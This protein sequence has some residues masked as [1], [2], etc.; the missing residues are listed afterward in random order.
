MTSDTDL[1][2]EP[3][4]DLP[5]PPMEG[6]GL[7]GDPAP[8]AT[9]PAPA[10]APPPVVAE[11]APAEPSQPYRVLARKYRPLDFND[12]IGQEALVR[13]LRNAFAQN[14]VAHAFMLTGVR[15]VGKTTTARIIARALN[16]IGP[17]GNGG[18]TADPCGVCPECRAI[19]A[20]RHPD[21]VEMDAASNNSVDNVREIREAVRFRPSQGRFKVYILDEVHMLSGAAFNALLKTLEEPPPAVKFL[22]ATTEIRKVPA[23]ILSR[24][25]RFDLKRVPQETLRAHFARIVEKEGATIEPE[26][27]AMIARA[28]D[29]SVRDGLSLL[30]QAIA[31]PDAGGAVSAEQVRDML[32]LADRAMVMDL[33]EAA[34]RGDLPAVLQAM[35]RAHER[36]ADPG[37]VLADMA[38]L[39]HTLTRFR[40]VPALR[41]DPSIPET[42]RVRGGALAETLTIPVLS[43]AWQVLLKGIGEVADSPDRRAAA[44][45][46]LIRLAHLAEMPTP[47]EIVRRLSGAQAPRNDTGGPGPS[48]TGSS[49]TGPGMPPGAMAHAVAGTSVGG[50]PG[51]GLRA[52]AGGAPMRAVAEPAPAVQPEPEV[53]PLPVPTTFREVAALASGRKPMLHA[54]LVHSVHLVRFAEGRIELRTRPDAPRDLAGQLTALLQE[55]TGA[56]WTVSLSNAEGEPTL[57][58]QRRAADEARL[59]VARSH[60]LVL[61][62]M[63]AFPGAQIREVRDA[64]LDAYGL[65]PPEVSDGEPVT[66]DESGFLPSDNDDPGF[67]PLDAEPAGMD[68]P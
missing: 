14:R 31:M 25:Q 10:A 3:T 57:A 30:D 63:D 32:G 40:A 19:L 4:D 47:G 43:R 56:R 11:A 35:D 66:E 48:G 21:V 42:E 38:E 24:C 13:T 6:P 55:V 27:L 62:V 20:D 22:F 23:T 2:T 65:P 18:P 51:G 5:D 49:G 67:A 17:D 29:G 50:A 1:S 8:P 33:M 28:A 34:M 9:A 45:M 26:A 61:A 44:E 36:G 59:E 37:V 41:N 15:G 12:L 68:R 52:I 58:E 46:V 60:P 53:A 16:C 39:T 7:F 64:S 54:H